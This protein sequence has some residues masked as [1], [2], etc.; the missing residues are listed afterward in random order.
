M[1]RATTLLAPWSSL[2]EKLG[3]AGALYAEL[4]SRLHISEP[5][6]KRLCRDE[7]PLYRWQWDT[8]RALFAAH[9]IKT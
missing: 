6:A 8:V 4:Q 3:G 1:A 2:A 5:T 9:K 7:A